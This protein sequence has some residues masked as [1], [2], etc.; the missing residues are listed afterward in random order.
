MLNLA[1]NGNYIYY[2]HYKEQV[3]YLEFNHP[4]RNNMD[5]LKVIAAILFLEQFRVHIEYILKGLKILEFCNMDIVF[6]MYNKLF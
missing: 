3:L 6:R 5:E 1:C 2:R 4:R